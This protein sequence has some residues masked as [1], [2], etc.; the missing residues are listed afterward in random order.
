MG[1]YTLA[2]DID[3]N[4]EGF[5]YCDKK[6]IQSAYDHSLIL[7]TLTSLGVLNNVC[8]VITQAA[9]ECVVTVSRISEYLNLH[10]LNV[11]SAELSL[12]KGKLSQMLNPDMFLGVFENYKKL[13]N[14]IDFP[15]V[16][17]WEGTSGG[18]GVNLIN[19]YNEYAELMHKVPKDTQL[20]LENFVKGRHF[21]ILGIVN[22]EKEKIYTIV[23]KIHNSNLTLDKVICPA[24]IDKDTSDQLK[25][26]VSNLINKLNI[27]FGPYQIEVIVNKQGEIFFV[28]FEPSVLGSY[29][30][31]LMISSTSSNDMIKDSINLVCKGEF[32]NNTKPTIFKS[33][34]KYYYPQKL[35]IVKN[36]IPSQAN[37][38]VLF[39]PYFNTGDR[40]EDKKM[41]IANSFS[42]GRNVD[43]LNDIVDKCSV[44]LEVQ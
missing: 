36:M 12:Q 20:I 23:E 38:R 31:E 3:P 8:G 33:I 16:L 28:E 42:I 25:L 7:K 14:D 39:K 17:K 35:G 18:S 37:R 6:L 30:S 21:G 44:Q 32:D 26:Y 15:C 41:Y 2:V 1:F 4:A 10:H 13:P 24:Q 27:N 40:L 9:R 43:E 11:N 34:L 5:Q 22:N 19:D 29:L